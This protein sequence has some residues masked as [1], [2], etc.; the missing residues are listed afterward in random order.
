M[1]HVG[2]GGL[3]E[4]GRFVFLLYDGRQTKG[5]IAHRRSAYGKVHHKRTVDAGSIVYRSIVVLQKWVEMRCWAIEVFAPS[6]VR[7][8]ASGASAAEAKAPFRLSLG[9]VFKVNSN[10]DVITRS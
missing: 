9:L 10:T 7:G 5:Q 1:R 6:A 8:R 3:V 4:F 2:I